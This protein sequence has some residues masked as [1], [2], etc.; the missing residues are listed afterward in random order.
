MSYHCQVNYVLN[1]SVKLIDL[2]L[3]AGII[4]YAE[5]L[6]CNVSVKLV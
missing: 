6:Y 3:A 2:S 4:L 1:L 5:L